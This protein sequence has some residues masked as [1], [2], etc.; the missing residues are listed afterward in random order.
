M[1][2][3]RRNERAGRE[4]T[5]SMTVRR[6]LYV[7]VKGDIRAEYACAKYEGGGAHAIEDGRYCAT[8]D[9]T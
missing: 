3:M 2:G 8:P 7:D 6:A 9:G 5:A 1:V 4:T